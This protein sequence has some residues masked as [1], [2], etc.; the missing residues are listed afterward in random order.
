MA[1]PWFR[2]NKWRTGWV[3]VRFQG[4][5]LMVLY[6]AVLIYDGVTLAQHSQPL[7]DMLLPFGMHFILLTALVSIVCYF[8][9]EKSVELLP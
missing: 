8:T 7:T 3:P 2:L 6:F 9:A 1:T 5:L 4:W